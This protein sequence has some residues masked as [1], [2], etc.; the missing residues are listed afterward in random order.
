MSGSGC[1]TLTDCGGG[2]CKDTKIDN[3]NCGS[4]GNACTGA[5]TCQAGTCAC[6]AGRIACGGTCVDPSANSA[7]CGGCG[8][9]CATGQVCGGGVCTA[10]TAG[11]GGSSGSLTGSSPPKVA[12]LSG[13]SNHDLQNKLV[14]LGTFGA[15]DFFDVSSVT[16]TVAQLKGYDAV[17]LYTYLSFD[18][19][20]TFSENLAQYLEAGG[21][22]V[23]FDYETQELGTYGLAGRYQSTYTLSNP[24]DSFD[25]ITDGGFGIG[26]INDVGSPIF[27]G[28][29]TAGCSASDCS[30]LPTSAF[31][32][33]VHV[34][35]TW[36]DGTPAVVTGTIAGHRVAEINIHGRS[37]DAASYDGWDPTTNTAVLIANTLKWS[38]PEK[39]VQVAKTFDLGASA[40]GTATTKSLVV[41]NGSTAAQ[42]ITAI[43]L[44]GSHIGD[45]SFTPVTL[46]NT[47]A[48]AGTLSLTIKCLPSDTGLRA[49]TLH[50]A[51]SG[52]GEA[53][54]L[55][56]C[57]GN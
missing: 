1:G 28:V 48:A 9:A 8:N 52:G 47:I 4:C 56:T 38:I 39:T 34:V 45:F 57:T 30:H 11:T 7:N 6:P 46:P 16:P 10:T 25:W 21:G 50:L 13:S 32:P 20:P 51:L 40:V 54:T 18:D 35:A 2:A 15:V 55:L 36:S 27:A 44:T 43:T 29:T 33:G 26:T 49:A 14:A 24:I 37:D 3:T 41:T 17:A 31:K 22:V 23:I 19:G 12:V 42:T 5:K 53:T